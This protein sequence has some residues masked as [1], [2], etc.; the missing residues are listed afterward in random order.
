MKGAPSQFALEVAANGFN[1]VSILLAGRNHVQTWWTGIVGCMLFG[2][3]FVETRLYADA[4]LQ[5]FFVTTSVLG[6]R[7]WRTGRGGG[8]RPIQVASLSRAAVATGGAIVV[9][10]AYGA[11]L[12]AWTDAYAPY[13]D[14]VVLAS[15]VAAQW[16]LMGRYRETWIFWLVANTVSVPLYWSRGLHVTAGLYLVFW[17]H[18]WVAWRHWCRGERAG[19]PVGA[20][21]AP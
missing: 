3:L 12:H 6:W 17:V 20:A 1:V 21:V 4:T 10:L 11:L 16:L 2:T 7:R 18:A 5:A 9:T 19:R 8:D 15:S 13:V 14:S